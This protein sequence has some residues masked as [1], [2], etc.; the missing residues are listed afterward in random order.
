MDDREAQERELA[1]EVAR[2]RER[3]ALYE[4]VGTALP[5]LSEMERRARIGFEALPHIS[6]INRPDGSVEVF[7]H[8]WTRFTGLGARPQG[9]EWIEAFHPEDRAH[10]LSVREPAI[11]Q[12]EP[13]QADVRLRRADGAYRWHQCRVVPLRDQSAEIFAWLGTAADIDDLHESELFFR[14]MIDGLPALA[15]ATRPDGY[16][17]LL[18]RPWT[19]Y[20]GLPEEEQ[21]GDGWLQV[22]HPDDRERVSEVWREA[23]AD[24]AAYALEYRLRRHDGAYRWFKAQGRPIRDEQGRIVR[25]FGISTDIEDQKG[26]ERELVE[27][28]RIAEEASRAKDQ[29]LA[30]LSHELRTRSPPCSPWRRCW[31]PTQACGRG[32]GR[33]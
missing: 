27:A 31:R 24:R 9:K 18:S 23:V 20:A 28:R 7:N 22:V 13:Y 10:L 8:R 25:W 30:V 21:H 6:W 33:G 2:L 12:G 11:A 14:Q 3:L 26:T 5:G 19:D 29:F 4:S 16:C 17:D 1:T 32:S 15:W